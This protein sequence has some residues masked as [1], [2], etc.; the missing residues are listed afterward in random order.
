VRGP[1]IHF[2]GQPTLRRRLLAQLD[3]NG[4]EPPIDDDPTNWLTDLEDRVER[5]IIR[6][7]SAT[8]AQVSA[9]VPE[10]ATTINATTASE[11][12]QCVTTSLLTLMSADGRLVRAS[13]PGPGPA[14][15][16]AGNPSHRGGQTGYRHS[17]GP[18]H[19]AGLRSDGSPG[20][21]RP[22]P[23]TSSGGPAG[24]RRPPPAPSPG[25]LLTRSTYTAGP[26]SPHRR[27]RH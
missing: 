7:G 25:Y 16:T 13:R 27:R 4:T 20:S 2:G 11:R 9:E 8:G 6:L 18:M 3:R 22:P 5:T 1:R 26:G 15:S 17:T 21:D 23:T 19:N 14:G 10:L 12:P 24:T